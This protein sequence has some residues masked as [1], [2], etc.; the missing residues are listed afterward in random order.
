MT[1]LAQLG[2]RNNN[3]F[4]MATV[5]KPYIYCQVILFIY[6]FIKVLQQNGQKGKHIHYDVIT[7]EY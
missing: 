7:E 2:P 6:L 1:I 3:Q 5:S 4:G